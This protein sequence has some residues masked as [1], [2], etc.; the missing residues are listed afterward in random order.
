MTRI[1]HLL[2]QA[3]VVT[4]MGVGYLITTPSKADA[5]MAMCGPAPFCSMNCDD[6]PNDTW[7][8]GCDGQT[9]VCS[10]DLGCDEISDGIAPFVEFCGAAS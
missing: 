6:V 4:V 1:R 8:A 7:C 2:F 3:S 9:E 5:A 10:Y